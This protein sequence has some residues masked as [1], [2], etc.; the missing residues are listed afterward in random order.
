MVMDSTDYY[1][2]IIYHANTVEFQCTYPTSPRAFA[3]PLLFASS[4]S[5]KLNSHKNLESLS[6]IR[7]SI[8]QSFFKKR[9]FGQRYLRFSYSSSRSLFLKNNSPIA[10]LKFQIFP[11]EGRNRSRIRSAKMFSDPPSVPPLPQVTK[12]ATPEGCRR[13]LL[14]SL[15]GRRGRVTARKE[16]AVALE[17]SSPRL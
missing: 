12:V 3:F 10:F 16:E 1:H 4:F 9:F 5:V 15:G 14:R 17:D 6:I 2:G 7:R 11:K 8:D 13:G